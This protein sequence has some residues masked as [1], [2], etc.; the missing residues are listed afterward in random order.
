MVHEVSIAESRRGGFSYMVDQL[1]LLSRFG[2]WNCKHDLQSPQFQSFLKEEH[3]YDLMIGEMFNTVCYD[4]LATKYN[5][6]F[7][8][9]QVLHF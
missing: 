3:K 7:V 5:V 9:K 8:G 6:P 2:S 4:G 1:I